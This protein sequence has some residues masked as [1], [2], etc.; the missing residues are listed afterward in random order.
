MWLICALSTF[1]P[2]ITLYSVDL[3]RASIPSKQFLESYVGTVPDSGVGS[4]NGLLV[5]H[6]LVQQTVE[7]GASVQRFVVVLL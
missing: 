7:S 5:R 2:P 6:N 3:S 4:C 1:A